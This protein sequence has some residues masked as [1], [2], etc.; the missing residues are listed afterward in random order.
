MCYSIIFT[1]LSSKR[2][3]SAETECIVKPTYEISAQLVP[4][5]A[6]QLPTELKF[7]ASRSHN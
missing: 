2:W 1:V 7:L 5:L 3:Y 6:E 4:E